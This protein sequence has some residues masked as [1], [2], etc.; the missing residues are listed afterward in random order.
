MALATYAIDAPVSSASRRRF[1]LVL[2]YD[3]LHR[4]RAAR[5]L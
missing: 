2:S 3:L 1:D 4:L 5:L